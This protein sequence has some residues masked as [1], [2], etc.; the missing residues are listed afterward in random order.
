MEKNLVTLCDLTENIVSQALHNVA[1]AHAAFLVLSAPMGGGKDTV[2]VPA[3]NWAGYT[4]TAHCSYAQ[5][6]KV[7]CDQYLVAARAV[8]LNLPK[9]AELLEQVYDVDS[10]VS[11]QLGML[12][13]AAAADHTVYATSRTPDVRALLQFYG[14]EVRRAQ[15]PDYWVGRGLHTML[16]NLSE[17]IS[18]VVTDARFG[19]EVDWATRAGAVVVRV[20]VSRPVQEARL[21]A[22]DGHLPAL[23]AFDHPSETSLAEYPFEHRVCSDNLTVEQ[24]IVGIA[25]FLP[26]RA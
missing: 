14:T 5:A 22:R 3:L 7:D 16:T 10:S 4:R 18:V 11:T 21:L 23:A 13:C 8:N 15:N 9:V 2:A 19:N 26:T 12:V 24:T 1:Q 20:D 17:G 6:L 25:R